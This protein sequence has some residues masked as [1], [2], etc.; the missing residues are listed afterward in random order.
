[1]I[2]VSILTLDGPIEAGVAFELISTEGKVL[3]SGTSD[4]AG[5]VSFEIDS[6]GLGSVAVRL[7]RELVSPTQPT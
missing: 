5:V 1:M 6:A 3:G 7:S 4:E 2:E